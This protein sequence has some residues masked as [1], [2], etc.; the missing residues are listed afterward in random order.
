MLIKKLKTS[1][2]GIIS[3][4][5]S[6]DPDHTLAPDLDPNCCKGYQQTALAVKC[7]QIRFKRICL[8]ELIHH[9]DPII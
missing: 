7:S 6:F 9:I 4:S 3:E 1:F 2:L 5:N 8:L